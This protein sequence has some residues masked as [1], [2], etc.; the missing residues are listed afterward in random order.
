[1]KE[2]SK[3]KTAILGATG[4]VGQRFIQLLDGHPWF[5]I[6]TVTGSDRTAGSL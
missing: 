1:M 6:A 5:D 2:I 3:L 4:L